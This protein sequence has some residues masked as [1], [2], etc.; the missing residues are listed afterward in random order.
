MSGATPTSDGHRSPLCTMVHNAGWWCTMQVDGAQHI[1]LYSL[2]G[3]QRK[4][5]KPRQT[6]RQKVTHEPT[7]QIAHAG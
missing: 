1:V 6:D 7:V 5:H 4:S 2:G 3:A